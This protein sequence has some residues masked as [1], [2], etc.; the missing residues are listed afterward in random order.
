MPARSARSRRQRQVAQQFWAQRRAQQG[1][2]GAASRRQEQRD[3][4]NENRRL[5][6]FI[7][8][9]YFYDAHI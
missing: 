8:L 6:F 4:W 1:A 7:L 3:Q 2:Q 9:I 5:E